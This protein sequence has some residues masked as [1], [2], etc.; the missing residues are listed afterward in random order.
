VLDSDATVVF[1]DGRSK[2][3]MLTASLCQR[4]GKPCRMVPLDQDVASAAGTLQGRLSE[5]Q[6]RTLNIAGNC[7]SQAPGIAA[8]VMAVLERALGDTA[9]ERN[10]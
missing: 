9:S 3:S 4:H 1:G 10:A 6:I 8:F 5:H 7:A 2:G